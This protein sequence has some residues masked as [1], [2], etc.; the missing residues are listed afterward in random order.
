M[1]KQWDKYR[2][3]ITAEYK[4]QNKPLH[5]VQRFM[6][7]KYGFRA[8]TRAYRSRFDRWGIHKYS[9][10]QRSRS[11]S[12]SPSQRDSASDSG[13]NSGSGSDNSGNGN[14]HPSP[15]QMSPDTLDSSSSGSGGS[16]ADSPPHMVA[17]T[18]MPTAEMLSPT[19]L[20]AGTTG[21]GFR[22][23][24]SLATKQAPAAAAPADFSYLPVTQSHSP[25]SAVNVNAGHNNHSPRFPLNH[26]HHYS[27]NPNH[28]HH[29]SHSHN[30]HAYGMSTSFH[31][32]AH[33]PMSSC[34]HPQSSNSVPVYR[35]DL[36]DLRGVMMM[37]SEMG[38]P[39]HH[40]QGG[41]VSMAGMSSE[42]G[43]SFGLLAGRE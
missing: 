29:H 4:D 42:Y 26:H 1:T 14:I 30:H 34:Y 32:S 19:G 36:R 10:R 13:S 6:A 40:H 9:R 27:H 38:G 8:S 12:H 7:Q 23:V 21:A 20:C 16:Q 11:R 43:Y 18:A 25:A 3:V 24:L 28:N 41:G 15:R 17:V 35:Q 31:A 39:D 37:A 22:S 33:D 2:G 5:E